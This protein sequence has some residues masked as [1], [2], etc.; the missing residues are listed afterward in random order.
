M[1]FVKN[2]FDKNFI[3]YASYVIR[4]RAIPDLED[5][6]KPVQRRIMHTLFNIDDGRMHKVASVV[7][8]CMKFHPHG[9]A[10][11]GAA[12]V[13]LANKEIFI[14]R[15][16]NFGN[17]FTGDTASAS[18]YIECCVHPLAK[19]FLYN[20]NITEYVPSYDGRS[21]EPVAFRAKIPVVLLG[22]AEGI[23]VGM[24]TKIL[25]Y[26]IKEVLDAEIKALRGEPF[27][28][29]PDSPT[30]GLMDVS[31]YNDGNGKIITRAKFDLSDEKKIV[32][33]E[34]PLETTSKDLLDSIDA[35]Y[36]AGKIKISS[37]EDFTTDH[38]N[39]EIKLPRG[40][41]SKDVEKALY[42]YT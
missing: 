12:L 1:A 28:I 36:K 32:I 37:V 33:T 24:S 5:G 8:D 27:E 17:L 20:P 26:N 30:G 31:N 4:D 38:C 23:A 21:K 22:G 6:L 42:A 15:Q 7:G 25:P 10:S 41:Y 3:E 13:V 39:I 14:Q 18:R 11:I 19:K 16:G 35:A 2:L 40:V 29:Y 34:L 9:D